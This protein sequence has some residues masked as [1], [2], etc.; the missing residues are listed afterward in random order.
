[1]KRS[2]YIRRKTRLRPRNPAR[3]ARLHQR[4]FDGG[5][6]HDSFARRQPCCLC[7]RSS[8]QQ[9]PTQS[10]HVRSR[11]A[12]GDWTSQIPLCNSHHREQEDVGNHGIEQRYG[13]DLHA[14][15]VEMV[16]AHQQE[17]LAG[18]DAFERAAL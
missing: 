17:I 6:D 18:A 15:A 1:M 5:I 11:G 2:G 7:W 12:G 16:A 8:K 9:T 4:N 3:A 10:A 13:I 14:V